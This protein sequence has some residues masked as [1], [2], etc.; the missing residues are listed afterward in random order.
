VRVE[1]PDGVFYTMRVE[2]GSKPLTLVYLR[3]RGE[4]GR[5]RGAVL[6]VAVLD[7]YE[8]DIYGRPGDSVSFE[9][10]GKAPSSGELAF[11]DLLNYRV[12]FRGREPAD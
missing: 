5:A 1:Q 2:S 4:E 12:V 8:P 7:S 3:L 10:A 11:E 6:K 9:Y